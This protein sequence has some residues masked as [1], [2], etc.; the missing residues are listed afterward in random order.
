MRCAPTIRPWRLLISAGRRSFRAWRSGHGRRL[1]RTGWSVGVAGF[2]FSSLPPGLAR[3][4][5]TPFSVPAISRWNVSPQLPDG[6]VAA[7]LTLFH[8]PMLVGFSACRRC[9]CRFALSAFRASRCCVRSVPGGC[10]LPE[11]GA[12]IGHIAPMEAQRRS[13]ATRS[14]YCRFSRCA[15]VSGSRS[16]FGFPVSGA[17][18]FSLVALILCLFLINQVFHDYLSPPRIVRSTRPACPVSICRAV[19]PADVDRRLCRRCKGR[20]AAKAANIPS[21]MRRRVSGSKPYRMPFETC[22]QAF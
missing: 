1:R 7:L 4:K 10:S 20:D 5:S 19:V 21:T 3:S 8:L 11:D 9:I 2:A 15:S 17:A 18:L 16:F 13:R 6:T 12:N 22:R 14:Y